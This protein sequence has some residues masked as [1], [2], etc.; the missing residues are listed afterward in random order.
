MTTRLT[1]SSRPSAAACNGPPPP[2]TTIVRS[3]GSCPRWMVTS[4]S[5]L[6][7]F[8]SARL[9]TA[10]AAPTTD[11]SKDD[12]IGCKAA[13]DN[14]GRSLI[15]PSGEPMRIDGASQHDRIGDR[16]ILA[17]AVVASRTR[18]GARALRADLE[19]AVLVDAR[20][21]SASGADFH[22]ID[23]RYLQRIALIDAAPFELVVGPQY[24]PAVADQ[25]TLRRRA[26]NV[27]IEDFR[28]ADGF[29]DPHGTRHAS[30]RPR[31]YQ[32]QR[33]TLGCF[34]LR[35]ATIRLH[36]VVPDIRSA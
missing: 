29:A 4:F 34:E 22:D 35:E 9:M 11:K 25:R 27:E 26:A 15:R 16:R 21:R 6:I 24:R 32:H 14:S 17:A 19:A 33:R 10:L 30:R 12:A 36:A 23:D 18:I 5:A 31:F 7:M 28:L 2:L 20:D 13:D 8:A 3:R 1:P